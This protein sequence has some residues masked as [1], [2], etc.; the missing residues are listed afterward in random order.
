MPS[1]KDNYQ[2]PVPYEV[3]KGE[4]GFNYI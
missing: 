2:N 4:G 1:L 3:N